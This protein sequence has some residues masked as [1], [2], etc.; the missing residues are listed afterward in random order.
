MLAALGIGKPGQRILDLGTGTGELARA[1]A[2]RG[3][4]VVGVD[5]AANQ[6]AA[7]QMLAAR[8]HLDAKFH[9]RAAEDVEFADASFDIISAG[10][11][12][13]YFDTAVVV[14][15]VLRLLTA[16][17]RLVLTNLLW[18]PL[19]DPIARQTEELVL[20]FNPDWKGARYNGTMRPIFQWTKDQFE[21]QTFHVM[22]APLEF[23]RASWRGRIRACRGVGASL[24]DDDVMRFD[25]EHERLLEAITPEVFTV[26]HQMT[27]HAYVRKRA[28][29]PKPAPDGVNIVG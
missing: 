15:K 6:I 27:V 22:Q 24:S 28:I 4:R 23:T 29:G 1:F 16:D 3:A 12:W 13:Q 11:S 5:I 9:V 17:G 25:A 20:H 18:L 21:L 7:A 2:K 26:L 14:P 10:Q 19:Q 8:D